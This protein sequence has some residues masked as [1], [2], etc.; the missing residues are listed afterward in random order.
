MTGAQVWR[1]FEGVSW[2]RANLDGW[3][4]PGNTFGD[5]N[6]NAVAVF[7]NNLYIGTI[8]STNGGEIWRLQLAKQ[9]YIPL[10]ER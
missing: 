5:Y 8:S 2:Q 10:V 1:T 3:G 4:D 7:H 6:D 9:V